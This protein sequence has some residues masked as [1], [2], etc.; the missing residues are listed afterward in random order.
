MGRMSLAAVFRRMGLALMLL[1]LFAGSAGAQGGRVALVIGNSFYRNVDRL[2]NPASDARLIAQTLKDAGFTLIGDGPLL[3]LDKARFDRSVQAFGRA[4]QGADVALFYYSGHGMQVEGVNWLVPVDAKPTGPRDLDFQ[5]VDAS[6]VLRQ[7]EG[8]GTRLNLLILDACRN[9]PFAFRGIRGAQTGLAEMRA[10]EGTLIS[11]ATQPGNV[12]VDGDAGNSPY[13]TALAS[14][15]KRPAADVF[16]VFNQ[17]GLSVKQATGGRQQPWLAS[18]PI[19]GNFYFFAGPVTIQPPPAA[20]DADAVFWQSI[21]Q[22]RNPADYEAYLRRFPRGTFAELAQQRLAAFGA[23]SRPAANAFDGN[24]LVVIACSGSADGAKPYTRRFFATVRNGNMTGES[25]VRERPA[26][27]LLNGPI[28]PDGSALLS[29]S[30]LTGDPHYT[31]GAVPPAT[32][33]Q[34]TLQSRFG[35]T[36]GSGRR[37]EARRRTCEASFARQ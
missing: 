26:Y 29:V 3:D 36:Q 13:T 34:F 19:S 22:S 14:A 27:F 11:Y 1:A 28:Q 7:M 2:A 10:P 30:G 31:A 16:Q 6:L 5:M 37:I 33:F 15:I 4:L 25:G 9:N 17:V 8:A 18:S 23:P 35:P 12:A 24:W 20:V 32:P 21:T